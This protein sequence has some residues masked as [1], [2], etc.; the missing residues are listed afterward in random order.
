MNR[1]PA[2]AGAV[3]LVAI[4]P[5]APAFADVTP[6]A[7]CPA[8]LIEPGNYILTGDLQ[9]CPGDVIIIFSSNVSLNLNGKEITCDRMNG[10]FDTG[11]LVLDVANIHI[12]NG[13]IS[14][15]DNGIELG[16]TRESTINNMVLYRNSLDPFIGG[17]F[18]IVGFDATDNKI[19]GN[20]AFENTGGIEFFFG[21]NNRIVGNI[22][23]NN[24][25][26]G[27]SPFPSFGIGIAVAVSNDNKLIGNEVNG[28]SDAGIAVA[29]GS[30]GNVVRGNVANN[31]DNYG[32]GMFSREDLGAPLATGNLNQS[33]TALGNGRTD[34]LEAKFD[35]LGDPREDVQDTCMNTWKDNTFATQIVPPMCVQ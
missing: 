21:G 13:T 11:I 30:T 26:A 34:I 24:F 28:N 12:R 29:S 23:N 20:R 10:R 15:C 8:E 33:N 2:T 5:T 14:G 6:V 7:G 17:G 27:N 9:M 32:I 3:L 31:N 25:R 35:S 1:F 4:L 19:V 18:G 16:G 22:A